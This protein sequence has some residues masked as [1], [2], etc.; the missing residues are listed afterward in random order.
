MFINSYRNRA[1]VQVLNLGCMQYGCKIWYQ[2]IKEFCLNIDD[3]MEAYINRNSN[4][5]YQRKAF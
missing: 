1:S 2:Y 3:K 4:L 5:S